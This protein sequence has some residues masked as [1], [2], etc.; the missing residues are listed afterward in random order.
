MAG[1]VRDRG[2]SVSANHSVPQ[3]ED[4]FGNGYGGG[5][6][7]AHHLRQT[8]HVSR[9]KC[10]TKLGRSPLLGRT[11]IARV[12]EVKD[13][14]RLRR[15]VAMHTVLTTAD[16]RIRLP[17]ESVLYSTY[18]SR[19]AHQQKDLCSLGSTAAKS[20]RWQVHASSSK[21]S[22]HPPVATASCPQQRFPH[23][24]AVRPPPPLLPCIELSRRLKARSIVGFRLSRLLII[25]LTCLYPAAI[26]LHYYWVGF[27]RA[28]HW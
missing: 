20:N 25:L 24:E 13:G 15:C 12:K 23:R 1:R 3:S 28:I 7:K 16:S 19:R 22:D 17:V 2:P 18:S 10:G 4:L 9:H 26:S 27:W 6:P 5:T 21:R 14:E 8:E 11:T